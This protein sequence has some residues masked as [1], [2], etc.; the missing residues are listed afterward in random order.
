MFS[1]ILFGVLLR[2]NF[3]RVSLFLKEKYFF[4]S[5]TLEEMPLW[6]AH[7]FSFEVLILGVVQR[8]R[9]FVLRSFVEM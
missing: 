9:E 5:L 1:G 7:S 3:T 4:S 2:M 6:G 8:T